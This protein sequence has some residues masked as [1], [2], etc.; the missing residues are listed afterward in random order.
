[1]VLLEQ[2]RLQALLQGHAAVAASSDTPL[3]T[4]QIVSH[5]KDP[6]VQVLPERPLQV[7]VESEEHFLNH[8]LSIPRRKPEA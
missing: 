4:V 8:F 6:S 5:G 2:H 3:W 7:P 1:L